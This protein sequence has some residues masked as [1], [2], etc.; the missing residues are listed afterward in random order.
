MKALSAG[1][2][3]RLKSSS[4]WFQKAPRVER[5][6]RELGAVVDLDPP[7]KAALAADLAEDLR[8]VGP[9][10]ALRCD[11]RHAL[12]RAHVDHG[13]HADRFPA[14]QRVVYEVHCP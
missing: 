6:R 1:L 8:D 5:L 4:A 13:P 10:E 9:H 2:P 14:R 11:Q 12:S 7:G 3:G